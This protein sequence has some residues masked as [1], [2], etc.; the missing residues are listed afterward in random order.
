MTPCPPHQNPGTDGPAQTLDQVQGLGLRGTGPAGP[1]RAGPGG[2]AGDHH[3]GHREHQVHHLDLVIT[4]LLA[5]AA[6][7]QTLVVI[8]GGLTWRP[9][10]T[11]FSVHSW[12]RRRGQLGSLR[13]SPC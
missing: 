13:S 4:S 3:T 6:M 1:C 11:S 9:R 12:R 7:G 2:L 8:L 10:A 5:L